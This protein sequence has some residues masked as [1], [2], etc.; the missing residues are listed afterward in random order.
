ML[1]GAIVAEFARAE[2]TT[3]AI[4]AAMS[5]VGAAASAGSTS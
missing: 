1:D 4:G 5:G 2:A 3:A